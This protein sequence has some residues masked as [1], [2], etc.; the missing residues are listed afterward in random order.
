MIHNRKTQLRQLGMPLLTPTDWIE[1][2]R[3]SRYLDYPIDGYNS[4]QLLEQLENRVAKLL[5]K[6]S[7]LFFPKG[8]TAQ[9]CALRV[10]ADERNNRSILLHPKS[11]LA[12]DEQNSY[13]ELVGLNGVLLGEP[14]TPF[15]FDQVN[16]VEKAVGA[17]TVELPIRRAGFKLTPW[18]ELQKMHQWCKQRKVHFHMDGARL[19][20]STSFYG[21]TLAEISE[22]FDSVYVSLYKGLGGMGGAVLAGETE[23]IEQCKVWRTRFG[24]DFYTLFPFLVCALDGLDNQLPGIPGQVMRAKEIA[25]QL[26]QFSQLNVSTPHTNGFFVFTEGSKNSINQKADAV[27][28]S[29]GIQLFK[30]FFQTSHASKLFCEIQVGAEHARIS[31]DEILEYF[32]RLLEESVPR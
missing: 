26:S 17:L 2:L 18:N 27:S 5:G 3:R 12:I 31:N 22:L 16:T 24:S 13:Q 7:A 21:K 4:G 15:S 8:V 11:H 28:Q 19:W 29:M 14:E 10:A 32:A 6:P 25:S 1:K 9:L 20:E 30:E 23:F